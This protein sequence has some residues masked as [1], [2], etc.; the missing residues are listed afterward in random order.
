M[1]CDQI[2]VRLREIVGVSIDGR[3]DGHGRISSLVNAPSAL[4]TCPCG[5]T[6]RPA[7]GDQKTS[8]TRGYVK[9][10]ARLRKRLLGK[11]RS[12]PDTL[13]QD[14]IQAL[15]NSISAS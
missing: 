15:F 4:L 7:R 10:L 3:W 11:K 9:S 8:N 12:L 5:C 13:T 14:G 6:G 2:E 1:V